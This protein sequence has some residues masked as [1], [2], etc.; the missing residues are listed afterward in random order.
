MKAI[1]FG[2]IGTIIETSEYQ[3]RSF[4]LAFKK[5]DIDWYWNTATYCHL[6]K[7][8]GG[9]KRINYYSNGKISEELI[10]K[11]HKQKEIYFHEFL[12]NKTIKPRKHILK[13]I[14]YATKNKIKLGFITTT[15]LNNV[16][17]IKKILSSTINFKNFSCITSREDIKF[18]KPNTEIYQFALKKVG[19]QKENVIVIEDSKVNLECAINAGIKCLFYPG[20]FSLVL[21]SDKVNYKIYEKI[22][23]F[24]KE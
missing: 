21:K 22:R 13:I 1:F 19:L 5:F 23:E 20:E 11:I 3:R 12:S 7:N 18:P 2:S 15:S 16:K 10:T 6:L 9:I 4:N 24:V 17:Y 8:P 14:D